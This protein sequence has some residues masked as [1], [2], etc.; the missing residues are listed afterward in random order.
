MVFALLILTEPH[1]NHI[2]M[3]NEEKQPNDTHI[4]YQIIS[5]PKLYWLKFIISR[6]AFLKCDEKC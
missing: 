6:S 1:T 5:N 4:P 3:P 2:K